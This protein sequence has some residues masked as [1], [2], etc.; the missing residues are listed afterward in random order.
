MSFN[1][2]FYVLGKRRNSTKLPTGGTTSSVV[3]ILL[4]DECDSENPILEIDSSDPDNYWNYTYCYIPFFSRY[5]FVKGWKV[6]TGRRLFVELEEDYLGSFKSELLLSSGFIKYS[7]QGLTSLPDARMATTENYTESTATADFPVAVGG[8]NY[9]IS[10]VGTSRTSTYSISRRNLL[11]LFKDVT[12]TSHSMSVQSDTNNTLAKLGELLAD[13]VDE[14]TTQGNLFNYLRS[15][16]IL[17]F[18]PDEECLSSDVNIIAGHYNTGV[19]GK[20][21]LVPVFSQAIA[22]S[23]PWSVSDWRR[24][25]PYTS[26]YLYLPFIGI[27]PIDTNSVVQCS[28]L[29]VKYSVCYSDGAVSYSVQADNGRIVATGATNVRSEYALGSSNPGNLGNILSNVASGLGAFEKAGSIGEEIFSDIANVSSTFGK[30]YS[31]TGGLGGLS[32]TGLELRLKCWTVTK[33]FADVQS[34]FALAYGYPLFQYG[35]FTNRTGYLETSGFKFDASR[36]NL[37]EKIHVSDMV[38]SGIYI[39]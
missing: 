7:L 36:A 11:E 30:G 23:I 2:T 33:S 1:A 15:C 8:N 17:P 37:S 21:L 24:C 28:Y 14:Y 31:T 13:L 34:N 29:T 18:P 25:S 20:E 6:N 4:K 10:V 3:P 9:F 5:Y 16:Y 38:N 32:S 27:I 26:V 19:S 12:W 39:E 22:I 35:S